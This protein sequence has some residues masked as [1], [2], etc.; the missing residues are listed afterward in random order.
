MSFLTVR[1]RI[2]ML[3]TYRQD[4]TDS[5]VNDHMAEHLLRHGRC[6]DECDLLWQRGLLFGPTKTFK[7]KILRAKFLFY[8]GRRDEACDLYHQLLHDRSDSCHVLNNVGVCYARAHDV[9]NARKH[10]ALASQT[11]GC[12]SLYHIPRANIER[13]ASPDANGGFQAQFLW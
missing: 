2:L 4:P 8:L 1:G 9:A 11:K 12:E 6:A 7:A 13:L 3:K 10:Y 5:Y